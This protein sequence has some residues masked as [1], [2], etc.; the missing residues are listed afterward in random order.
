M[1]SDVSKLKGLLLRNPVILKLNED[2]EAASGSNLVQFTP[3]RPRRT[4]SCSCT[5]S[6]SS[7]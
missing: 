2:D 4:S 3:R 1:T 7:S 5:S 6:S